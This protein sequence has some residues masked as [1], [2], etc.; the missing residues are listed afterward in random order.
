[1]SRRIKF[2]LDGCDISFFAEAPADITLEQLLKQCDRIQPDYCACGIKSYSFEDDQL[3]ISIDYD[4][5]TKVEQ[6]PS[7]CRILPQGAHK[8]FCPTIFDEWRKN[9][10]VK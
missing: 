7:S 10:R 5:V 6:N 1:M 3:E 4:D 2:M 8:D 9:G